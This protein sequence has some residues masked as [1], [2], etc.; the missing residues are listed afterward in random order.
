MSRSETTT[1]VRP[2]ST[3]LNPVPADLLDH[4]MRDASPRHKRLFVGGWCFAP[5]DAVSAEDFSDAM[6]KAYDLYNDRAPSLLDRPTLV[7]VQ[8]I[9]GE[10]EV[11]VGNP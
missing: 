1:Y 6:R 4:A 2:T 8:S 9:V 3:T 11:L 7:S 5:R 10:L